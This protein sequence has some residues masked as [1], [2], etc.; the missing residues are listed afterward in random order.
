[1]GETQETLFK[2]PIDPEEFGVALAPAQLRRI[3][4]SALDFDT[5]QRSLVEYIRTY[6]PNDFNDFFASNGVIMISELISFVSNVLSERADILVD[7]S[8]ISTAFTKQAVSQHLKL[9]NEEIRRSTPAVVDIEISIPNPVVTEIL[10]PAGLRFTLSGPDGLPL[11]YELFRAPNDFVS[12]IS[13]PPGK[14]GVIG[15]GIEGNFGDPIVVDS[16]GGP[17]QFIDIPEPNVIDEPITVTATTGSDVETWDRIN[18]IQLAGPT[19]KVFEVQHLEESTRILFGDDATGRSPLSGQRITVQYRLG[20]GIRGRIGANFINE[21]LPI[22]PEP[23]ASA[24]IQARF[25]NPDPSS[26]GEDEETIEQ[27]KRRAPRDFATQENAVSGEDYT[28]LASTF[29]HPVFGSVSKSVA[30][31]RSGIENLDQLVAAVRAATSEEEATEILQVNCVNRNIVEVYV[32]AEGPDGP[33][34]P[35]SGLKQG[36]ISF[37]Q[38][39]NVLTDEVRIFDGVVKPVDVEATVVVSRNADAGT[40]KELV[41]TAVIDFFDLRNFDMG[42]GLSISNLYDTIQ[43]V[44]GV[45]SVN[46]FDPADNILPTNELGSPTSPGIGFNEL[47]ILG[48]LNLRYFFELGSFAR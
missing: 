19:D 5:T 18:I 10:I 16:P 40:T 3:D 11:I 33:V 15:F 17:N 35:S 6:F 1:M 23:P 27:S 22:T 25:R 13:I 32:L 21:S 24:A 37:F 9:I 4:F 30:V 36:L 39:I 12:S 48:D 45:K 46:I 43:N 20:G 26:G 44:A 7:E 41:D 28:Q 42:A 31:L 14:R 34:A 38:E 47:I 29:S 8:F 2:L